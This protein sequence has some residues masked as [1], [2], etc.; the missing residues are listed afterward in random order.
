VENSADC[1]VNSAK[2]ITHCGTTFVLQCV[3]TMNT[4]LIQEALFER[5]F[6]TINY[7]D[8]Q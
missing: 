8:G 1:A 7:K 2:I 6:S 5:V 3:I 4:E